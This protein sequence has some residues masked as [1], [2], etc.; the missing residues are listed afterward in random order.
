[1][2][3]LFKDNNNFSVKDGYGMNTLAFVVNTTIEEGQEVCSIE[4]LKCLMEQAEDGYK[5]TFYFNQELAENERKE[6]VLLTLKPGEA[7]LNAGEYVNGKLNIG[8]KPETV[9][10][11]AIRNSTSE[12]E[13]KEFKYAP[14]FKRPMTI[15]DPDIGDELK[16]ILYFD[17]EANDVR[18]KIKLLPNKS[19]IALEVKGN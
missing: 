2:N 19:Y 9:A 13:Y 15:I 14:N 10:Y 1:M 12:I 18:A 4:K 17:T 16:P 3:E 7:V 8:K 5:K 6:L 11:S